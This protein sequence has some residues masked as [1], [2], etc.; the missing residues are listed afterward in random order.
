MVGDA[1]IEPATPSAGHLQSIPIAEAEPPIVHIE[2]FAYKSK[3]PT[4]MQICTT[5][6]RVDSWIRANRS[7]SVFLHQ[8]RRTP[9]CA[10]RSRRAVKGILFGTVLVKVSVA[11][12]TSSR[13]HKAT[14]RPPIVKSRRRY[15]DLRALLSDGRLTTGPTLRSGRTRTFVCGRHERDQDPLG[16]G[17]RRQHRRAR[18]R[19]GGDGVDGLAAGL[20]AA[21]RPPVVRAFRLAGLSAAGLLLVVV[22]LRR[23]RARR[24]SSKA[25]IS[26]LPAV[27]PPSSWRSP[28]RS[29]APARSR[30]VT[31]YGSARWAETREVGEP[32]CSATTACCSA[33]GATA[34]F[35]MTV[36]SMCSASR[37]PDP[38]K[39]SA[40]SCRRC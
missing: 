5:H 6:K 34:I 12:R 29:G 18:L 23:L 32:G 31:T 33:T 27:S 30:R 22:R 39:V 16:P 15:S 24:S 13:R 17:A 20:P 35:A 40:S 11:S 1:G 3:A 25:P 2:K 38:A 9:T 4:T 37:R 14:E 21:A 7:N 10:E 19:L 8:D 36:P 28:C 26:R